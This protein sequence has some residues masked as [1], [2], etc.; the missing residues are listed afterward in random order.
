MS[1]SVET[2]AGL[3]RKLALVIPSEKIEA[4]VALRIKKYAPRA[5][6]DGFRPGK[7]PISV[8]K[9]KYSQ[10]I[11]E[12]IVYEWVPKVINEALKEVN[13]HPAGTP[14][15]EPGL[16]Q[17][18]QDFSFSVLFEEMPTVEIKELTDKDVVEW[19]QAEVKDADIDQLIE[20]LRNESK[21]WL[22][23][24]RAAKNGDRVTVDF[25]GWM[26]D[27]PFQG[28]EAKQ[29]AIVLG[30]GRMIPG[31]E[32][33]L[34]GVTKDQTLVL[35]LTFPED[36]HKNELAGQ[37]VKFDVT[38]HLIEEGQLPDVDEAFA[39]RFNIK[40]G[41]VEGLRKELRESMEREL[42]NRIGFLNREKI[43]D[44]MQERNPFDLPKVLIDEEIAHLNHEFYHQ[45]YGN[46]H[47]ENEKIPEFP[48]ELFEDKAKRRVHMGLLFSAYVNK[49]QMKP[50]AERVEAKLD[51][52]VK[53]YESPEEMREHYKNNSDKM[54]H[55][56]SLVLE[57]MVAEKL[58]TNVT[59]KHISKS[60]E[61][62][63]YPKNDVLAEKE[64]DAN[65]ENTGE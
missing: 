11:R 26:N 9:Q 39:E 29:Y 22:E 41:G 5:K 63:M 45:I 4:E 13:V 59:V 52:L 32:S 46:H 62:I 44:L 15:I 38:V 61:E 8:I 35:N 6:I 30:E 43:F 14:A 12:E 28:G 19:S 65:T 33:G 56:S 2:L 37:D 20:K 27:E 21:N 1:V 24:T 48:R 49:H 18:N 31:F 55:V 53:A 47:H 58:K 50:E 36:Y 7:A 40:E 51:V 64:M 16:I 60:Y 17:E 42:E 57:E 3:E 10:G 34:V 23:V 54:S 25:K